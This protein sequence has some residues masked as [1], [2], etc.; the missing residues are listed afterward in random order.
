MGSEIAQ[1]KGL[2]RGIDASPRFIWAGTERN[3]RPGLVRQD[4]LA[5]RQ[6]RRRKLIFREI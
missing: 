2:D 5:R 1:A 4:R 3:S 6:I